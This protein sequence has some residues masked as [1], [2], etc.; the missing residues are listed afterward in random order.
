M[1]NLRYKEFGF[2]YTGEGPSDRYRKFENITDLEKWI[3]KKYP[4]AIYSSTA[5]YEIPEEMEGWLGSELVFDLDVKDMPLRTCSCKRGD[6]C[7][8]CL[9]DAKDYVY[10]ILDSLKELGLKDIHVIFSGRGYHI[11][12]VDEEI[13]NLESF[14]RAEILKFVIGCEPI[15]LEEEIKG[16][17]YYKTF[18]RTILEFLKRLDYSKKFGR[19]KRYISYIK[20]ILSIDDLNSMRRSKIFRELI[21]DVVKV[22]REILDSKVTVDLKRLIRLPSSLHSK[23]GLIC[24]EVKNLYKFN[25]IY[26]ARPKVLR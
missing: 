21:N 23:V 6:V 20:K 19:Y 10:I 18:K 4:Y 9:N 1:R 26:D 25:P 5:F 7:E 24:K 3:R 11:R 8:I 12:V 16:Y 2:D 22:N 14:E 13:L 17:A 15:D